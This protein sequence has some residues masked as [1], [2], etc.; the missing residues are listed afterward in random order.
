MRLPLIVGLLCLLLGCLL[1]AAAYFSIPCKHKGLRKGYLI[2]AVI[3]NAL[4][5]I[6]VSWPKR[7]ADTQLLPAIWLLYAWLSVYLSKIVYTIILGIS[8]LPRVFKRKRWL[9]VQI[10]GGVLSVLLFLIFWYGALVGRRLID[11]NEVEIQSAQLPPAFEGYRIVQ[12]S[13]MHV[14]TWGKDT[15]FVAE[16]VDRI[17][18]L[19][20]DLIV[21]TGDIV[22]R[23]TDEIKPFI[24]VLSRLKA[25]DGVYSVLGNHDYGD[26]ANWPDEKAHAD[27][28]ARLRAIE[29]AMGWH[30]LSDEHVYIHAGNDSIC[31]VGVENWGE[32][33]FPTYGNLDKAMLGTKVKDF[34]VLLSHN[35]MHWNYDVKHNPSVNLTL[36]GH[37]HA[38]QMRLRL[39][40]RD[41]SFS[42]L[43]YPQW[44]GL[45]QEKQKGQ[46]SQLYVNI[47]CGEVGFPARIFANSEITVLTLRR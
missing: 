17:N 24:P 6:V 27:N 44:E 30:L 26:Y 1:D 31:L 19:K 10:A 32:P 13:D 22:N 12:F 7:D 18:E 46:N 14:G 37:T 29:K 8:L 2:S 5:L 15:T 28:T 45:Y 42:Q 34:T 4:M 21:F 20:P 25:K 43:K 3:T 41:L 23:K 38:M 11:V 16:F 33:P 39:P 47:G 35:P 40:G 9:M 36:S